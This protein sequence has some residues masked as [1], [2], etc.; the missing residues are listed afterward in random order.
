MCWRRA[1]YCPWPGHASTTAAAAP[2]PGPPPAHTGGGRLEGRGGKEDTL[3]ESDVPHIAKVSSTSLG[4][5]L[6]GVSVTALLFFR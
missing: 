2:L 1:R 6:Y 4:V 5:L 3:Y